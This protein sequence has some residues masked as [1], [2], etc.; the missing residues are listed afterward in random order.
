MSTMK[1]C[2]CSLVY[3]ESRD[4]QLGRLRR[5]STVSSVPCIGLVKKRTT[6][7][8]SLPSRQCGLF[9]EM[10]LIGISQFVC[11]S[12]WLTT[13]LAHRRPK[14]SS[15]CVKVSVRS[16]ISPRESRVAIRLWSP[17]VIHRESPSVWFSDSWSASRRPFSAL[18]TALRWT[19]PI[20]ILSQGKSNHRQN[21]GQKMIITNESLVTIVMRISTNGQ[22]ARFGSSLG[23]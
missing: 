12:T 20:T 7:C 21:W 23:D 22:L 11:R 8:D 14:I 5:L 1:G 18:P 16:V 6:S 3:F 2:R 19:A 4:S 9:C 13:L 15:V 10:M 17:P